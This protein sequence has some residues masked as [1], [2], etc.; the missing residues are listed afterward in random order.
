MSQQQSNQTDVLGELLD[1]LRHPCRRQILTQL[2][3]RNHRD[4]DELDLEQVAGTGKRDHETITL[5]HSHLPK[6]ADSG[7]INWDRK[8]HVVTRG[9]RFHEIAP[10]ID[11]MI[12]HQD[13]LPVD[14]P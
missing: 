9:P 5:I 14:W 10:L 6:L 8:R 7:F 1:A 13:E 2:N 3:G 11:L 4:E 12:S